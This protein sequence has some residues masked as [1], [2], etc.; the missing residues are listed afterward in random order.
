MEPERRRHRIFRAVL[1][2]VNFAKPEVEAPRTLRTGYIR[3]KIGWA[4]FGLVLCLATLTAE[5]FPGMKPE[6]QRMLG[7]ALLMAVWWLTEA[8]PISVTALLPLVCFPLLGVGTAR[9]TS[10]AYGDPNVFLFI[11][12]FM[13]ASCMQKW[14]LHKRIALAI[15]VAVGG[16]PTR[17]L[18]GCMATTAFLSMWASNTATVMMM[19]PIALALVDRGASRDEQALTRFSTCLLLGIAYAGSM[20][21]TATL[22]GTP[23]N[24]VFASMVRRLDVG[25]EEVSF[26]RWMGLGVPVMLVM[27]VLI[28]FMLTRV[29]F[30]FDAGSFTT[31]LESL[32]RER[33][34]LGPM[35]LGETYISVAFTVTALL[36]M[37][38]KDIQLGAFVIPGWSGLLPFGSLIHDGTVAIA[39]SALLF[40]LPVD[41]R[42]GVFLM[43][44][45][46]FRAIP[47]DIVLLFGGGFALAQGFVKSGLSAY[48]GANLQFVGGLPPYVVM[49]VICLFMTFLTELTSNTAT[50]TVM[51]PILA[52][53]AAA[54]GQSAPMYML[55]A[56][57]AASAAFMLPVATPPNA[58]VFASGRI[59]IAQMARAGI[60]LNLL[61]APIIALLCWW[62]G[63]IML[64][65]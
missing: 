40:L 34:E 49:L 7:I 58:I 57:F 30:R 64:G 6:A 8:V 26:L 52:A 3:F 41:R 65:F 29:L 59:R 56:T 62:L 28:F 1:D 21:G 61:S 60:L 42:Q 25:I 31:D 10:A 17:I 11:G 12:G 13:L 50:T 15:L 2:Y 53:T 44:R 18:L 33:R 23:P 37:T 22:I 19:F 32:Q 4:V 20:G 9:A 35:S 48:L 14:N 24:I 51:L 43:D 47:W 39:V 5:P 27:L 45:D 38:R 16:S 54:A 36:W 55:P 46:W 63:P